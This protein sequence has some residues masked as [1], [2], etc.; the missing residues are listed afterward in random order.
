MKPAKIVKYSAIVLSIVLFVIAALMAAFVYLFP[1]ELLKSIIV[2]TLQKSLN[3]PVSIGTIDYS[4]RGIQITDLYIYDTDNNKPFIAHAKDSA[5]RFQLLPLLQK[6]FVINYIYLNN[7]AIHIIYYT[8]NKIFT[9][10]LAKLIHELLAKEESSIQTQ[11]ESIAIE[12]TAIILENPPGVLKPLEGRYSIST[13]CKLN[14]STIDLHNLSITMPQN[15]GKVTGDCAISKKGNFSIRGDVVLH[16]CDLLWVYGWS[17]HDL[18]SILPYRIFS[19]TVSNLLITTHHVQGTATGSC[20]LASNAMIYITNGFCN[21]DIDKKKVAIANVKG[22]VENSTFVLNQLIFNFDG[23]IQSIK[24][25]DADIKL[26]EIAPLLGNID[27]SSIN[28]D[29]TGNASYTGKMID[30]DVT[31]SNVTIGK[32]GTIL[33][34]N[35]KVTLIIKNNQCKKDAIPAQV[36]SIPCV[37]SIATVDTSFKKFI[38]NAEIQELNLNAPAITNIP[39]TGKSKK[40]IAIPVELSGKITIH[41]LIKD[42]LAINNI[43]CSYI[44]SRNIISIPSFTAKIFGGDIAGRSIITLHPENPQINLVAT[45]NTIRL[46]NISSYVEK[47]ENRLFGNASGQLQVT[48]VPKEPL[49]D[50]IIGKIEFTIDNGKLANTGLQNGLSIWLADLKYK[51]SNLE[52]QKIYGNFHLNGP[53]ITINSFIFN[54][55]AIRIK[56][57]G[58]YHRHDESDIDIALEFSSQFIQDLPN[59]TLLQLA[60]YKKGRWYIIPFKAKGTDILNGK[61]IKQ[62]Q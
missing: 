23:D 6:Q 5:I 19:G 13:L 3:R 9:S 58:K 49:L 48:I 43:N 33:S 27:I 31:V 55:P 45:F 56:L 10:N 32:N 36:Y 40:E 2:E 60:K 17:R 41:T 34:I 44:M 26:R 29:I 38:I 12:N 7:G 54:A 62:V 28:A 57:N 21:V 30:A 42:K 4:L 51:L 46:Q 1:R 59:P 37:L 18:A 22:K 35:D 8:E 24:V 50:R 14:E 20:K 11:I 47:Y 25:T 52:F 16:A 15:R 61:N 53:A 39:G